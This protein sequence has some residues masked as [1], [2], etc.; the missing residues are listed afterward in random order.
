MSGVPQGSVLGPA[1]FNIFV[2]DTDSGIECTLSKFA[3]LLKEKLRLRAHQP[4]L[5]GDGNSK[6]IRMRVPG[7]QVSFMTK[8]HPNS[9]PNI[10]VLLSQSHQIHPLSFRAEK[11]VITEKNE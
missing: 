4:Q 1:L 5:N 10:T 9:L 2:S 7:T 6:E 8:N 11:K 3:Q